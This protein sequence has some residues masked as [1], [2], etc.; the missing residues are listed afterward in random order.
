MS[1]K[2]NPG[3]VIGGEP[4]IDFLPPEVKQ[5]KQSRRTRRSLIVLVVIVMVACAGG[6]VFATSLAV[7]SQLALVDEQAKTS[8]LLS[9]QTKYAEARTVTAQLAAT[10]DARLVAT[11]PEILWRAYLAEVQATL[12]SGMAITNAEVDSMSAT[13]LPPITTVPLETERVAT[14]SMTAI[15][16]T[17]TSAAAWLDNMR[18]L[19]G[20]ADLWAT[21]ATWNGAAYEIEVRL[22]INATAFE[23]RF[24]EGYGETTD[25][26]TDESGEEA[27]A[28]ESEGESAP[29]PG[30]TDEPGT[31]VPST[32]APSTENEG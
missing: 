31:D 28:P 10:E 22:N 24:F 8:A 25:D 9:E 17:L 26:A 30:S 4:R 27:D 7:Q 5:R 13:D 14:I 32:E 21:P 23:K 18:E 2:D 11:A 6:F 15:A 20:F 19:N 16:P 1:A 12:P 3:L 29:E